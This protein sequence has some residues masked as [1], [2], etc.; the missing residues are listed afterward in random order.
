MQVNPLITQ[1]KT[2]TVKISLNE[3]IPTK[4]NYGKIF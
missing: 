1:Y 2:I 3:I 4:I